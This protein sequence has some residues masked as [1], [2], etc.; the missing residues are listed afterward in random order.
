[1]LLLLGHR[2][3]QLIAQGAFEVVLGPFPGIALIAQVALGDHQQ[4][5]FTLGVAANHRTQ[6]R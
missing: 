4:R 1:M 3:R 5:I 6:Q 2:V